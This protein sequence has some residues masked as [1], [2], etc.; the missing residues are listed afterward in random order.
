MKTSSHS[1]V[2]ALRQLEIHD[3]RRREAE[4]DRVDERVELF[5]E[6][7]AGSRR[8]RDAAIEHVGDAAED[9]ERRRRRELRR[10]WRE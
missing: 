2:A 8:A 6:S 10:G 3:Q 4:G 1:H 5:A 7:A 9:D